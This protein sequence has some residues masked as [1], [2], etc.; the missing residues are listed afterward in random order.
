MTVATATGTGTANVT[1]ET[2]ATAAENVR[3]AANVTEARGTAWTTGNVTGAATR[4]TVTTSAPGQM[5]ENVGGEQRR[6][7]T[8]YNGR[9]SLVLVANHGQAERIG[10]SSRLPGT[11]CIV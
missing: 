11:G 5:T 10:G 4:R 1:G 8:Y 7:A 6:R 3:N 9:F 2:V